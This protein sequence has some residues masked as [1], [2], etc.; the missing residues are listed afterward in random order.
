MDFFVTYNEKLFKELVE[1]FK[2]EFHKFCFIQ[3]YEKPNEKNTD[4]VISNIDNYERVCSSFELIPKLSETGDNKISMDTWSRLIHLATRDL[5]IMGEDA[6]KL[7]ETTL[8]TDA[9]EW[10]LLSPESLDNY[11]S[12]PLD[13]F[14]ALIVNRYDCKDRP[15]NKII[16]FFRCPVNSLS[17]AQ[18]K[19]T[20]MKR[21][22]DNDFEKSYKI[23]ALKYGLMPDVGNRLNIDHP[24]DYFEYVNY[25]RLCFPRSLLRP[26][27][28]SS[29]SRT[30][31][32]T[33]IS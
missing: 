33:K 23:A 18:K 9:K 6:V 26:L 7:L 28:Y 14:I 12:Q 16:A 32:P 30:N 8:E 15:E 24:M 11:A 4:D 22:E 3:Q 13:T 2:N 20:L 29:H 17:A 19:K 25:Y 31:R 10:F 1:G 27:T 5:E 21:L